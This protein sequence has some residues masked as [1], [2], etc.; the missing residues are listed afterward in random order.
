MPKD[1]PPENLT[2]GDRTQLAH[3]VCFATMCTGPWRGLTAAKCGMQ[4]SVPGSKL[5]SH[6]PPISC[7]AHRRP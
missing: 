5:S 6:C 7:S 3:H 4:A 2:G 1:T